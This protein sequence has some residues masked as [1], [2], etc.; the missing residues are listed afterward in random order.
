VVEVSRVTYRADRFV[1]T[2]TSMRSPGRSGT[3][4]AGDDR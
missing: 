4:D 1:F 2:M 3:S